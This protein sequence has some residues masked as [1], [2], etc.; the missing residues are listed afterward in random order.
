MKKDQFILPSSHLR[1]LGNP[2]IISPHIVLAELL[3]LPGTAASQQQ[4]SPIPRQNIAMWN[5][6]YKEERSEKA[7]EERLGGSKPLRT[8]MPIKS[9]AA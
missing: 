1:K 9:G 2:R 8:E 5:G 6:G 7:R 3:P 4:V